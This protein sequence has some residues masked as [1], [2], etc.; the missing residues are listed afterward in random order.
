MNKQVKQKQK[1]FTNKEV[2]SSS[3]ENSVESDNISATKNKIAK[4]KPLLEKISQ[5]GDN[6]SN[7]DQKRPLKKLNI[8]KVNKDV[9]VKHFNNINKNNINEMLENFEFF[10]DKI[11]NSTSNK[12]NID[13]SNLLNIKPFDDKALNENTYNKN[14]PIK[15][16]NSVNGNSLFN[17]QNKS[18]NITNDINLDQLYTQFNQSTIQYPGYQQQNNSMKPLFNN[19]MNPQSNFQCNSQIMN[20]QINPQ[21]NSQ[22]NPQMM[23]MIMSNPQLVYQLMKQVQ[24]QQGIQSQYQTDL[25]SNVYTNDEGNNFQSLSTIQVK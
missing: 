9:D 10:E 3:D 5:R 14:N 24:K 11:T 16:E 19:Q 20:S 7:D 17:Y 2:S 1:H 4:L 21:L 25:N 13:I 12:S 15:I 6:N 8:Q 18:Q 23:N 22:M